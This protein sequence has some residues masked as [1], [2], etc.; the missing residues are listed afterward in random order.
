MEK[1]NEI[2]QELSGY[3]GTENYHLFGL[4][5]N[6]LTDGMSKFVELCECNWL[7]TDIDAYF[8]SNHKGMN[9]GDNMF[10]IGRIEVEDKKAVMTIKEDTDI[11]P[12]VKQKYDYTNFPLKEF[13][14]YIIRQYTPD[15]DYF[16]VYLLK[17][18]Y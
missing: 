4:G 7:L 8:L 18:E 10:W 2:M 3:R 5:K 9:N 13:E 12:I 1:E 16:W 17:G 6:V 11:K 14:F 15:G